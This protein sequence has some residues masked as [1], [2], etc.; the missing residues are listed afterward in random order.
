MV[1]EVLFECSRLR[2]K[3]LESLCLSLFVDQASPNNIFLHSITIVLLSLVLMFSVIVLIPD[4]LSLHSFFVI[5]LIPTTCQPLDLLT[6]FW[7]RLIER[8]PS[9]DFR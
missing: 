3:C 8:A 4:N 1:Q 2:A 7:A 5:V 9:L 6:I